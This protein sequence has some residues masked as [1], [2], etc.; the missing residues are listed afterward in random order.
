LL[1]KYY[2]QFGYEYALE[3]GENVQVWLNAIPELKKDEQEFIN[4]RRAT[5]DDVDTI[6]EIDLA[7]LENSHITIP[8]AKEWLI[9]QINDYDDSKNNEN[10]PVLRHVLMF[11]DASDNT[12]G[13]AV[14]PTLDDG[15][16]FR[17][18]VGVYSMG[19]IR[20]IDTKT[21]LSSAMR[22]IVQFAKT[23]VDE[24]KFTRYKS[25]AF[26]LSQWHPVV[27]A[28][29]PEMRS[30]INIAFEGSHYYVRVPDLTKFVQHILPALN[31][32][33]EQSSTHHNYTGVVKIS[34]YTPRYP[35]FELKIENGIIVGVTE[36]TKS[37]QFRDKTIAYF[38]PY[39][40]LQVLFGMRSIQ[41][42]KHIV[43]DVVMEHDSK[44]LLDVI[45]PKRKSIIPHLM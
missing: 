16:S 28:I 35:G 14:I 34:N 23:T 1:F 31:R 25:L 7:Q 40:F 5:L 45:F 15:L 18:Y 3:F 6:L 39:S 17:A 24:E 19:F 8:L 37:E 4:Y 41:E 21:A 30:F 22:Q 2:R 32:R 12:V 29:H 36:F 43:P 44:L 11:E 9:S 33:L 38:P 20:G 10:Q 26:Y 42:L 13:Y 27:E